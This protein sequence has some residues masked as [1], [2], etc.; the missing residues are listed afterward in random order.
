MLICVQSMALTQF[1]S[2]SYAS[3]A[4]IAC[5]SSSPLGFD[6]ITEFSAHC[7]CKTADDPPD[8]GHS[9]PQLVAVLEHGLDQYTTPPITLLEAH[10]YRIATPPS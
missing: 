9:D 5:V 1:G 7:F 8:C 10:C 3:L 2:P 4:R 6:L